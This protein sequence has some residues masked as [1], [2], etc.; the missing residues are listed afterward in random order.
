MYKR[1]EIDNLKE[2]QVELIEYDFFSKTPAMWSDD[3]PLERSRNS[4]ASF[5][6]IPDLPKLKEF[7]NSV[8]HTAYITHYHLINHT[9]QGGSDLHKDLDN[10]PWALNIPISNCE[11]TYTAFYDN[12]KHE[13]G[14]ITLN[15]PYF[16][17][18]EKY[19]RI[20]NFGNKN[21]LVISFRFT[22]KEL[23]D[24]VK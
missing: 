1:I 2:I 8:V 22:G 14:R 9:G 7:L 6:G 19:H 12:N 17:N 3:S 18:I 23:A 15:A 11:T 24:V 16:L 5:Y 20:V 13:V 10:S 21:R 4:G